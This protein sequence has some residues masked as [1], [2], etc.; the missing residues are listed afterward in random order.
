MQGARAVL[1]AADSIC[2]ELILA[3]KP[4]ARVRVEA[5][6]V[7]IKVDG[8][9]QGLHCKACIRT[10]VIAGRRRAIRLVEFK[11]VDRKPLQKKITDPNSL[12]LRMRVQGI[13]ALAA[14]LKAAGTKI[15]SVS[16]E[17]Y[18]NGRTRWLMVE[19]PDNVFVQLT[20]AP[21][22]APNPGAPP[23]PR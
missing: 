3:P 14:K 17:P 4:V 20:E 5:E 22:G 10:R 19:G 11:G 18:T 9:I 7:L 8:F 23:L 2:V 21:P 13:D 1:A 16:G 6:Q 12:V 15:V